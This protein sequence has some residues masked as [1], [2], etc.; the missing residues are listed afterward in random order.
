MRRVPIIA[1]NWKMHKTAP[2]A[3][4][5]IKTVKPRLHDELM[6]IFLAVP[7]TIIASSFE[8]AIGSK[9]KIGAQNVHDQ[10]SGA[11]TGEISAPMVHDAGASFVILGHSERR[12]L[13]QESNEWIRRKMQ[14]VIEEGL[15]PML[16]VGETE[17]QRDSGRTEEVIAAQLKQ[18]LAGFSVDQ[19]EK[20]VIA[21]EPVWAIGTGK[22]ATG[23]LAEEVHQYIREQLASQFEEAFAKRTRILYGG[24]VKPVNAAALMQK[25]NIDGALIGGASLEADSFLEIIF[26]ARDIIS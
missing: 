23:E 6:E 9:I 10:K 24:S 26:H 5:F 16:C 13:F 14:A 18:C 15:I 19:L 8:D 3:E 12:L 1:A 2:E 4:D 17:Q 21:Y 25:P 22:T 11:F 20:L 7:F